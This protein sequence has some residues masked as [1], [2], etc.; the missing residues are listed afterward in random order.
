[1]IN[2]HRKTLTA[3]IGAAIAF[4]TSVVVSPAAAISASE[5]LSGAIGLATG[6]GVYAATNSPKA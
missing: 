6:L 1:M 2:Q 3:I 4:A 5:W